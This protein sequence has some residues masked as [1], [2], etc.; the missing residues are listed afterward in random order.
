MADAKVR[1][2]LIA[3]Y[4]IEVGER[5]ICKSTNGRALCSISAGSSTTQMRD[6]LRQAHHIDADAVEPSKKRLRVDDQP[7]V[8]LGVGVTDATLM[9]SLVDCFAHHSIAHVICESEEFINLLATHKHWRG[10]SLPGR[11][12]IANHMLN[13]HYSHRGFVHSI[14][15]ESRQFNYSAI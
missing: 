5:Y 12:R 3:A 13:Q 7:K 11:R 4:Y 2:A 10:K 9:D 15:H 1:N 6:H 8:D 14:D